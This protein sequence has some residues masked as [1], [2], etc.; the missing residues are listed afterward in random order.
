[1]QDSEQWKKHKI[2]PKV[3]CF[4]IGLLQKSTGTTSVALFTSILSRKEVKSVTHA[5]DVDF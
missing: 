1:M 4:S 3:N 5:V 2:K